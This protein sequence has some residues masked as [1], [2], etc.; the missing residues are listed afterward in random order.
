MTVTTIPSAGID[1]TSNFAFTGTVTGDHTQQVLVTSGNVTD[2]SGSS[3]AITV[4]NCFTSTYTAYRVLFW[5]LMTDGGTNSTAPRWVFRTGGSSGSDY[6]GTKYNARCLRNYS[7]HSTYETD[8]ADEAAYFTI[9]YSATNLGSSD[10]NNAGLLDF[11]IVGTNGFQVKC[12]WDYVADH[13]GTD[14]STIWN[15]GG[16]AVSQTTAITGFKFYSNDSR[17]FTHYRYRIYGI[18]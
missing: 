1:L 15:Q 8:N 16:G 18:K 17:N 5:D 12:L 11:L 2:G 7:G 9:G 10:S 6:T 13:S 14:P 4:D 3:T